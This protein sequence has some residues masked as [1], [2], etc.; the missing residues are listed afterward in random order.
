MYRSIVAIEVEQ[1]SYKTYNKSYIYHSYY[2]MYVIIVVESNWNRQ[3]L[4]GLS[5]VF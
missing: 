4:V 1:F 2:L 3:Y 5:I